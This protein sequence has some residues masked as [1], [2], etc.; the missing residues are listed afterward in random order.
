MAGWRL[1]RTSASPN[2][3]CWTSATV[4]HLRASASFGAAFKTVN[5]GEKVREMGGWGGGGGGG[6]KL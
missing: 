1:S 3:S 2:F 5:G 4:L 6:V